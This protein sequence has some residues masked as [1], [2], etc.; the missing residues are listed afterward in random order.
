VFLADGKTL[1]V[2][3]RG[4]AFMVWD[5][6]CNTLLQAAFLPRPLDKQWAF[7]PTLSP[8]GRQ[9]VVPFTDSIGLFELSSSKPR[10]L[11]YPRPDEG[12]ALLSQDGRLLVVGPVGDKYHDRGSALHLIDVATGKELRVFAD[13]P[14][15]RDF[16]ISPD[17]KLLAA[18]NT[19]GIRLWDT[20]TGT[21][22]ADFK[23]HRG[24]VTT[25]AF[26][27]DGRTLVSA[28]HDSTMLLWDVAALLARPKTKEP[29]A[30]EL[31]A[32]WDAL[33]SPDAAAAGK[34]MRD[35]LGHPR[36]TTAHFAKNVK[37]QT[38]SKEEIVKLV[39]DLDDIRTKTREHASRILGQLAE[40][41]EPELRARLAAKPTLEQRRRI[42]LLLARLQTPITDTDKLRALRCV[43]VLELIGTPQAADVLRRLA[44]GAE[45]AHVTRE[46][47]A[48]LRRRG[49]RG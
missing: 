46:A 12:R 37:P 41:A 20:A 40:I 7:V 8:D 21:C 4:C 32:L 42:D 15:I 1:V 19:E 9:L 18:C 16:S 23:G 44:R 6:A 45:G 14:S 3:D 10:G 2:A 25:V 22:Q 24:V 29:S 26:S 33:A 28:A 5:A 13:F 27:L 43:E 39:A 48:V 17:G 49:S 11:N 36:E 47:A 31:T 35:S 34:A 30:D 38:E